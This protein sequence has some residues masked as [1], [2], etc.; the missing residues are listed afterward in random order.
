M[1]DIYIVLTYTGTM[2]SRII[3]SFTGN[4]FAHVSIALDRELKNMYSFGRLNPYNPFIGGFVHEYIDDGTFKR[5]KNTVSK[6]YSL[7]VEDQKY[8]K[9]KKVICDI[10]DH[11]KDY[12]FNILGLFAA[13]IHIRL[14]YNKSF[15]CAEFVKYVL[16]K[17]RVKTD[18]PEPIKPEDFKALKAK[19]VYAGLLRDYVAPANDVINIDDYKVVKNARQ[20]SAV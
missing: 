11:R 15:Y 7:S 18:L 2:L 19:V 20:L 3:K 16:D 14:K 1:K 13:G 10:Q 12:T 6:V 9:L 4:E 8:E 17:S 5:F